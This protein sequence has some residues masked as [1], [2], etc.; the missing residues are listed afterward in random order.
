MLMAYLSSFENDL[1]VS[2][3][4]VDDQT[5]PGQEKGWVSLFLEYL[6][7]ALSTRVGEIGVVKIWR[8]TREMGGST[9]FDEEIPS[10]INKSALFLA[11]T[12]KGYFWADGY[13]QKELKWFHTKARAEQYGLKVG[14]Y[15]RII[16][17][18]LHN[19]PFEK[20]PS[21]LEGTT[22]LKFNDAKLFEAQLRE[23][24]DEV[25]K[26]LEAFKAAVEP[27]PL[28]P[29][30]PVAADAFKVF[31]A[32]SEGSLL[33][34][35]NRIAEQLR[36]EGI[37][38]VTNVPPP[39]TAGPHE[40]RVTAEISRADLS[41]HLL[42][43]ASGLEIEGAAGESYYKK[44]VEIGL[45]HAKSQLIWVTKPLDSQPIES[46]SQSD[47]L[48]RLENREFPNQRQADYR[49][50]RGTPGTAPRD[51]MEEIERIIKQREE[52][53]RSP[54]AA[55]LDIHLKDQLYTQDLSPILLDRIEHLFIHR[56]KDDP[57]KRMADFQERLKQVSVLIII[58]G[59][60]AGEWVQARLISA[61]QI[62]A[63]EKCPLKLCGIYLPPIDGQGTNRQL[64]L[65]GA[66]ASIPVFPFYR[67]EDLASLLD[68]FVMR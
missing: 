3:A 20:W 24:A 7:Y 61:L 29:P 53:T 41:V 35:R 63:A 65:G 10:S 46:K 22:G 8:D 30:A 37:Q 54:S 11:L 39:F 23:L 4:R 1:F 59:K 14:T 5:P 57:Q 43:G 26:I 47:F 48:T 36:Q 12:S 16:N 19:I 45:G 34:T 67:P 42:D 15:S 52:S 64:S 51:I 68:H 18:R 40:Q 38:V 60:V 55:L 2:Y 50:V 27:A 49:F 28:P 62:A 25:V 13:C 17:V 66:P 33:E 31:L 6:E 21:E 32:H 56:E 9:Y 58:F 44:Q